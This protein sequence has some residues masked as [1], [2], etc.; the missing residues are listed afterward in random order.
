MEVQFLVNGG[1]SLL[2]SP[3]TEAEAELL[4]QLMKQDNEMIELRSTVVVLN[5]NISRGIIIAKKNT[6]T[7]KKEETPETKTDG[8]GDQAQT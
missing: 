7:G 1:V 6:G 5:K 2:L 3:E 8:N 4:K